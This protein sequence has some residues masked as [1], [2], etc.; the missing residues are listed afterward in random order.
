MY[1]ILKIKET[2]EIFRMIGVK[3]NIDIGNTIFRMIQ[4]LTKLEVLIAMVQFLNMFKK[5]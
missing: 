1:N 2:R 5:I 4:I 3:K